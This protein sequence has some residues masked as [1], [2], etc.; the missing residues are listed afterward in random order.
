MTGLIIRD[1]SDEPDPAFP[2]DGKFI[3]QPSAL[4]SPAR[5]PPLGAMAN[6]WTSC[7]PFDLVDR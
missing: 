1:V 6:Q 5:V 4:Q 3:A 2:P 7:S